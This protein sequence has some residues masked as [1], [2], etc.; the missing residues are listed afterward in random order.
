MKLKEC[1]CT[2]VENPICVFGL[3]T[4]IE[5]IDCPTHSETPVPSAEEVK[6]KADYH[7]WMD[8]IKAA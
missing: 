6:A 3:K 5:G 7:R 8:T 2:Y 1:T 4:R